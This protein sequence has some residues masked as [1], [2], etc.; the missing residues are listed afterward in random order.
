MDMK[1]LEETWK[2][3]P[4]GSW[5][6]R[7]GLTGPGGGRARPCFLAVSPGKPQASKW[8]EV[9]LGRMNPKKCH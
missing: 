9:Y 6:Q 4:Q 3:S 1:N 8:Y 5:E 7:E 2:M